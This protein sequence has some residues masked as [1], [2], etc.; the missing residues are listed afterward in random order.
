MTVRE[1]SLKFLKLSKYTTSVVSNNRDE[2]SRFLTKITGDHE[3]KCPN[4][5]LHDNM[6]L[7]RLMM[8]VQQVVDSQKEERRL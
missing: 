5:M 8:Q 3:E 4:A 7:S 1:Y 6:D 2:M